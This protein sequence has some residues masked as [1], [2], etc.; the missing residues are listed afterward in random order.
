MTV[1]M[2]DEMLQESTEIKKDSQQHKGCYTK[3]EKH[4]PVVDVVRFS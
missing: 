4:C 3:A 1:L 2:K